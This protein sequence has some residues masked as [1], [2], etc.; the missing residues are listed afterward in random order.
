MPETTLSNTIALAADHAGFELKAALVPI[1]RERG[2]SVLDLGAMSGES[3]DYPDFAGALATALREARAHGG[4]C[5]PGEL[6]LVIGDD[7]RSGG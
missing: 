4:Q 1:L 6:S 5:E 3:V 7:H 2:L